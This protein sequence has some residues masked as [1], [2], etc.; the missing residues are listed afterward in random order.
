MRTA[1]VDVGT[2][3]TRLLIA[4]ILSG[5]VRVIKTGMITTRLG[6]GIGRQP[7]LLGPAIERTVE[8]LLNFRKIIQETGAEKVLAVATS[9]VRDAANQAEFLQEV[10]NR[11]GWDIRVLPGT[12]EAELSYLGASCG[13]KT[14]I[15]EPLVIDIGGGSTEFIWRGTNGL[16]GTSVRLGAVRMT[17][18]DCTLANIKEMLARLLSSVKERGIRNLVGVG[19]TLTTLAAVDQKLEEYDPDKVHGYVLKRQKVEQILGRFEKMTLDERK[20]VPGLQPERAD[21]VTAGVRIA[22]AVMEGLD[23]EGVTVSETGIMHGILY[24]D[25][26]AEKNFF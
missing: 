15:S 5:E 2:N 16:N 8:A 1:V 14:G 23:A 25:L 19:G 24:K 17:E 11:V 12:E 26:K 13:L 21:I 10:K 6:E 20:Q 18:N 3:T 4:K 22:L 9:A 7:Y